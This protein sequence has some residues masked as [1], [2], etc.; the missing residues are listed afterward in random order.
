VNVSLVGL[1][2]HRGEV[3]G[4]RIEHIE[5]APRETSSLGLTFRLGHFVK[6]DAGKD[7]RPLGFTPRNDGVH[8]FEEGRQGGSRRGQVCRDRRGIFRLSGVGEHFT[9][10]DFRFLGMYPARGEK[11]KDC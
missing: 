2:G 4:G 9:G 7:R 11:K 10:I 5:K 1:V 8:G 3:D 6:I